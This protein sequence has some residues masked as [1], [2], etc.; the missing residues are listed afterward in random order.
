MRYFLS[1]VSS[2]KQRVTF[3]AE[4]TLEQPNLQKNL[5]PTTHKKKILNGLH[6]CKRKTGVFKLQNNERKCI[7]DENKYSRMT[8]KKHWVSIL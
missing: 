6:K 3:L 1:Y 2:Q 7:S 4:K 5:F 8:R